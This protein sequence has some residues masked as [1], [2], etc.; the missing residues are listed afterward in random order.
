[1]KGATIV[2]I[3]PTSLE[4]L[5][6]MLDWCSEECSRHFA[7]SI[8]GGKNCILFESSEDAMMFKL[9]W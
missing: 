6:D 8:S 1:M 4:E 9:S 7:T 2:E 5:Y 3:S